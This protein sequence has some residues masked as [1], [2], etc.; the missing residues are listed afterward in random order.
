MANGDV[1]TKTSAHRATARPPMRR[2]ASQMNGNV[3]QLNTPDSERAPSF[4][5]PNASVQKWSR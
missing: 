5:V 3:A 1:A 4:D 2:P